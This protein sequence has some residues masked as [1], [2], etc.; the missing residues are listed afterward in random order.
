MAAI[1]CP[2][3]WSDAGGRALIFIR[4]AVLKALLGA[5]FRGTYEQTPRFFNIL[6]RDG[7]KPLTDAGLP[8]LLSV[9][10]QTNNS[11]PHN[12]GSEQS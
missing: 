12:N 8:I 9:S 5:G 1:A 3:P 10:S 4:P 6:R 11:K 7:L 2:C